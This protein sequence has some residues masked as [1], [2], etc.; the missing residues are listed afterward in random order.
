MKNQINRTNRIVVIC[1][2]IGF[3]LFFIGCPAN[4]T[5]NSG[6]NSNRNTADISKNAEPT[7]R[8]CPEDK[9]F[10]HGGCRDCID[11]P[12]TNT[13]VNANSNANGR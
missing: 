11:C 9:C 2:V 1:A 6:T 12:E 7:P 8:R 3:A 4:P 13:N 5:Q 10:C